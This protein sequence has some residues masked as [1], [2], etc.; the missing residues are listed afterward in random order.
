MPAAGTH[1]T[2][3]EMIHE[4]MALRAAGLALPAGRARPVSSPAAGRRPSERGGRLGHPAPQPQRSLTGGAAGSQRAAG[5]G[6]GDWAGPAAAPRRAGRCGRRG[7][8]R[9]P[10]QRETP[11]PTESFRVRGGRTG[12]GGGCASGAG[13]PSPRCGVGRG[14]GRCWTTAAKRDTKQTLPAAHIEVRA[15]LRHGGEG[16]PACLG[17]EG[18]PS[19][20]HFAGTAGQGASRTESPALSVAASPPR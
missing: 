14:R 10:P 20:P 11:G 19:T 8:L 6:G 18:S 1:T 3:L 16:L 15:K 9:R 7:R 12:E 17:R 13:V 5:P 2:S 4:T